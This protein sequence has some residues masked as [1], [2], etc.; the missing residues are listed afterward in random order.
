[1]KVQSTLIMN[2]LHMHKLNKPLALVG[3]MGSGKSHLGRDLARALALEFFDSDAAVESRAGLSIAEIFAQKGEPY[4]RALEG[5]MILELL[6]KGP[7]VIATGGGAVMAPGTLAA[8][9]EKSIMV[10][11]QASMDDMLERVSHNKDR[12]LLK[13]P[14]PRAVLEE[15][16]AVREP[17]YRQAHIHIMNRQGETSR[18]LQDVLNALNN[19][20]G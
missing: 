4:F 3:M 17:L 8:L 5:Q 10:W 7:C 6:D 1:M 19:V 16:M 15:L 9:A 11:V 2:L 14:N 18:A 13:N 20:Q 12:P